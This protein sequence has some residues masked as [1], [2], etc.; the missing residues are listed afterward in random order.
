MLE[1]YLDKIICGDCLEVMEGIPD[2]SID[3]IITDPPYGTTAC[4]WDSIIPFEPMWAQLH[5]V[6]KKN[7]AIV[8]FGSEPFSS[9]L[10]MSNIKRYKYDW[11]WDKKHG[12]G[13][14][15]AKKRPLAQHEMIS[16]FCK[17]SPCYYPIMVPMTK[18]E[19]GRSIE[20][21]RTVICGGKTTKPQSY[22]IRTMRYPKTILSISQDQKR[23]HPT[24]KPVVL[25]E[26]L[27]RTYT[28]EGEIV[29]DFTIGSGT[30]AV[31][32][33]NTGRHF[34]GIEL[35][36]KYCEIARRRVAETPEPLF[37]A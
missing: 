15:V 2:E 18:P 1:D 33:K 24:Q 30:T 26:Y 37:E 8:L 25:I 28:K 31:A 21:S 3:A 22:T 5:R 16:V 10:R 6:A 34:I 35:E 12:R 36:E 14:L 29:L 11:V 19:K 13:H 4:T 17:S 27:I 9:A 32:C 23:Y 7:A 20:S